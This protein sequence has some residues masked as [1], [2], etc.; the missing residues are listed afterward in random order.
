[1]GIDIEAKA[2]DIVAAFCELIDVIE[3]GPKNPLAAKCLDDVDALNPPEISVSPI[4][5]FVGD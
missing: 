1:M 2:T 5:P 3:K 4:A